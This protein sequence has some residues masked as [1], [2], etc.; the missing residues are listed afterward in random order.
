MKEVLLSDLLAGALDRA[1]EHALQRQIYDIVRRC[2]LDHTLQPG[3]RL[4]SSRALAADIGVSRIT[5]TLAYDRLIAENYLSS[6]GGSGT[7]VERTVERPL[8][9]GSPAALQRHRPGLSTRGSANGS[10]RGGLGQHTGA[11]VPGIAD[12]GLFPFHVW[13]RL[14]ARHLNKSDLSLAGY[15]KDGAGFLPLRQAIA[16]YLRISRSVVCEPAQ[17]ILTAGTHQSV[18]LCARLLTDPGDAALVESP[19]HWAFPL[20]LDAAGLRVQAA[21]LDAQGLALADTAMPRR[22]RMVLTSPS[23]QYPTGVVMPLARRL[24]LLQAARTAGLWV[25]ED[26][27]DSEFRYDG[28]PIPSLQGLDTDGRVIYMGT[29]S[30]TMFAGLRFSYIVVPPHIADACAQACARLY[31]PGHLHL[32]A[33]LADFMNDGHFAQNIKR[34]RV[35]YGERQHLLREALQTRVGGLVTLSEARSGL[36]VYAR[37][38]RRVAVA[39]LAAAAEE[40]DLVLGI[41]HFLP[42]HDTK[43]RN[44]VV[45]GYGGVPAARIDDGVARFARAL[46]KAVAP[47]RARGGRA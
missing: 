16:N 4:P 17:V 41:P 15:A 47:V 39:R 45:L 1:S 2:V 44:A 37:L 21:T 10:R 36:H 11:F 28:A 38:D 46:D 33:A 43:D 7:F 5:V 27:Y 31:R 18:D 30:K 3:Q 6:R 40:E 24:E 26:D 34:M 14:V 23:H 25:I 8:T 22:A 13:R 19:C 35:E 9:A 29:F 42:E 32:Q 20:V 12:A